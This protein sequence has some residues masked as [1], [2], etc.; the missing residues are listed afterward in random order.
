MGTIWIAP[1]LL[2]LM[3][4]MLP[5]MIGILLAVEFA[6]E[7][8]FGLRE[9]AWP[10]I[11]TDLNMSY[12]LVGLVLGIPGV[13]AGGF[14][15]VLGV[16]GDTRHRK[17][18][19]VGGGV[20]FSV[21]VLLISVSVN[22]WMLLAVTVLFYPASFAFVG[23]SQ[24]TLMDTDPTRHEQNMAR[25][26]FAG[27]IGVVLGSLVMAGAVSMDISWRWLFA[28]IGIGSL[29]LTMVFARRIDGGRNTGRS[30]SWR[31]LRL[32]T[33]RPD[34][35]RVLEPYIVD[36]RNTPG[37]TAPTRGVWQK[38]DCIRNTD[39]DPAVPDKAWAGWICIEPGEPG[40]WAQFGR[41][42]R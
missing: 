40:T 32:G 33:V 25:W 23:L 30:A 36:R 10:E 27:S 11:R 9:A 19:M 15:L 8:A 26:T 12:L 38:G 20:V 4:R 14:E 22:G 18:I 31:L 17:R 5:G 28:G 21:A 24:A 7:F 16:L 35:V 29:G 3:R 13:L 42:V 1:V 34:N 39:P 2:R 6:D 41:I 37:T